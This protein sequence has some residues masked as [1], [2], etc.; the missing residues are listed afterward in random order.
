MSQIILNVNVASVSAARDYKDTQAQFNQLS[1]QLTSGLR[2]NTASVDAAGAVIASK[3]NVNVAA[4]TQADRNAA[5]ANALL[6]TAE[7]GLEEIEA[8][9]TRLKE[10]AVASVNDVNSDSERDFLQVEYAALLT[11]IDNIADRTRWNGTALLTGQAG[12]SGVLNFQVADT[13]T[14]LLAVD[15]SQ[16]FQ[17]GDLG[18]GTGVSTFSDAGDAQ[19]EIDAAVDTLNSGR[20]AIGAALKALEVIRSNLGASIENAK[21]G[22]S[23]LEDLDVA[24]GITEYTSLQTTL[25]VQ[26]SVLMQNN[27]QTQ[28]LTKFFQI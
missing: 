7:A 6:S 18:L 16:S 5:Q 25:H 4:L 20:A 17:N 13:A 3:L 11:E 12:A 1:Q 10:L 14:D 27:Q 2:I 26:Q 21:N 9:T 22:T 19:T 8:L 23:V 15:L 28:A 24:E